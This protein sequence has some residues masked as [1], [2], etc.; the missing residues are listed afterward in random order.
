MCRNNRP[1][2]E[3]NCMTANQPVKAIRGMQLIEKSRSPSAKPLFL[4][5]ATGQIDV[6][7]P[8]SIEPLVRITPTVNTVK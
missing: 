3:Y 8:N 1:T 5:K 4:R 2:Y 7:F 6:Y